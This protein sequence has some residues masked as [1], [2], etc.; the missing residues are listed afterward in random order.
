MAKVMIIDRG[1]RGHALALAYLN[2]ADVDSVIVSPGNGGIDKNCLD[3]DGKFSSSLC[4][5][6]SVSL[7]DPSSIIK[8]A[9][10]HKPDL[11]DIAQDDALASGVVDLLKKEGFRVFGP[12]RD[13]AR[14]EWDKEW[15]REFMA[16]HKIACPEFKAF[17]IKEEK[18]KANDYAEDLLQRKGIIFF[19]AAGLYAGKGVLPASNKEEIAS[20]L[21]ELEKM[22]P[23]SEVFLIEE[24]LPGEE[25][26]YYAIV[27]GKNFAC[28][29][30]AQDNKRVFA[31]DKGPNT[32]GMGA[33]AP[34]L[35]TKDLE[36]QIEEEIIKP[37]VNGL[38]SEGMPY[39][40]ILYLGG[41]VCSGSIKVIEFNSR[42]GDP[43]C[44]VILPGI[45][46]SYFELVNKAID[47]KLNEVK[48]EEDTLSRV[49][50]V[51]ASAGYPREYKKGKRIKINYTKIPAGV[52]L[53][54]AGI[55][56]IKEN[57]C[58]NDGRVFSVVADGKNAIDARI[59]A[60]QGIACCSIEDNG[61]HY[62]PDIAWRDV[63]RLQSE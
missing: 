48:I 63:Q 60:L 24:G 57:L 26:S 22:G 31:G 14:I 42:W 43:E 21:A 3:R 16:R 35:V 54:S 61:L 46:N 45:K 40:G 9:R 28:F 6:S 13:A 8:S 49:C 30:S 53:L 7:K 1:A 37:A 32:G 2:N 12:S 11:I 36:K 23:A 19:K 10:I 18:V 27:D 20:A 58:T 44:H 52:Y 59:R 50:V 4:I 56:S 39:I 34:A 15:S 17:R 47:G 29:K 25:F 5:D 38:A 41:I 33:N 51:G 62:R 55:Q